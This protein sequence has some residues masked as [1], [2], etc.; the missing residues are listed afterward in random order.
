MKED[1]VYN[2]REVMGILGVGVG[3]LVIL[4]LA[5][6][7]RLAIG[8]LQDHRLH[9]DRAEERR[10]LNDAPRP[11]WALKTQEKAADGSRLWAEPPRSAR[12]KAEET[13]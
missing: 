6:S 12:T 1:K 10:W 4:L 8:S 13:K 7:V 9:Q 2:E 5:L 11:M 3:L